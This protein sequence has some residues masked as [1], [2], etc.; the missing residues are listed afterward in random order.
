MCELSWGRK[1]NQSNELMCKHEAAYLL[2][3]YCFPQYSHYS[4]RLIDRNQDPN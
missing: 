1:T 4:T 2:W 3:K